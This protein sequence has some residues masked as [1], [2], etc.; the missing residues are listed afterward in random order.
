MPTKKRAAN[1]PGGELSVAELKK[2][3][4][5]LRLLTDMSRG[6][7]L[8]LESKRCFKEMIEK[9]SKLLSAD[10]ISLMLLDEKK[11]ELT[12][13]MAKGVREE[14]IK[15]AKA[16]LGEG[17]AGRVAKDLKPI[18]I[19]DFNKHPELKTRD[20]RRYKTNSC[21][22]VPL[23]V[24]GSVVGVINVTDKTDG[25]SFTK[26]DLD[27]LMSIAD[28]V[29]GVIRNSKIYEELKRI[30]EMKSDFLAVLSHELKNPLNNIMASLDTFLEEAGKELKPEHA[31]FLTLA[32]NNIERLARLVH[33][34]LDISKFEAGKIELTRT[35][36]AI[37]R[38]VKEAGESFADL[39]R[40]KG[41]YFSTEAPEEEIT[42]WGDE[43]RIEQVLTNLLTNALKFT[44][45]GGRVSLRLE[46]AGEDVKIS[47][48]DTG[49][50]I[51]KDDIGRIF[52]K[53]C[54]ISIGQSGLSQGAGLGLCI[55]RDIVSMHKG[56]IWAESEE[57]KGSKFFVQLPK[58]LRK[59]EAAQRAGKA[60]A[61]R[62]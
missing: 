28:N 21:V 38:L 37:N 40:K 8:S 34:L 25:T 6:M 39:F 9:L 22:S 11:G 46:D 60:E 36:I 7:S 54:T 49:K 5:R 17:I 13:H 48:A 59:K 26:D 27:V 62:P 20:G 19:E 57:G 55:S 56:S 32:R 29:A 2:T 15:E 53:F 41:V 4:E 30:N 12:I 33:D 42:V 3:V 14:I 24:E 43:D 44:P 35:Q 47:V 23:V 45:Q 58:D 50:G 52:D 18:L 1:K 61:T 51:S 31:R 16:K 10:V